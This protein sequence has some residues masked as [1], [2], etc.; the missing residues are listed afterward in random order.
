MCQ[1]DRCGVPVH[2]YALLAVDTHAGQGGDSTSRRSQR[3][4]RQSHIDKHRIDILS[5]V[6]K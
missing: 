6:L 3:L 2:V 1:M 5:K 4:C